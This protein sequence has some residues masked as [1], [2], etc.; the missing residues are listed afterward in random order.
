MTERGFGPG[1]AIKRSDWLVFPLCRKCHDDLHAGHET[2]ETKHTRTQ[3]E[4]LDE[5]A[6]R[7]GLDLWH[8]AATDRPTRKYKRSGKLIQ[9]SGVL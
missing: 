9:H 3:A 6:K 1:K 4:M 7:L 2:W 5:F 8:F